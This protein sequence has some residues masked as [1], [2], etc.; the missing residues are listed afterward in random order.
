MLPDLIRE[1]GILKKT[2][3]LV[4][5]DLR[6]LPKE[7]ADLIIT[8]ADEVSLA[9]FISSSRPEFA[10]LGTPLRPTCARMRLYRIER[11]K[12]PAARKAEKSRFARMTM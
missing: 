2:A 10:K 6:K 9:S 11:S 3:A 12:W 4:N 1:I 5:R 8:A 7:K